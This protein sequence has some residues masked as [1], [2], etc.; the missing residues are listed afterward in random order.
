M[1]TTSSRAAALVALVVL[2]LLVAPG[3]AAAET[4]SGGTIVIEADET[5]L[6]D[7][8]ASGGTVL[9]HGRVTGDLQ[10]FAGNVVIDGEV[11]GNVE[12]F[13]GNVVI[14]GAIDGD[15]VAVAGN[16][17]VRPGASIGGSLEAAGGNVLVLGAV[18]GDARLAGESVRLGPTAAIG[19]SLEYDSA[20]FV[21]DDGATVAGSIE[22]N[23]DMEIGPTFGGLGA[24]PDLSG[25]VAVYGFL[26][27]LVLGAVLLT[28]FP[29]F[30]RAVADRAVGDPVRSGGIGL[31]AL[32]GVPI[33][34]VLVAVTIVGIPLSI[35][36]ALL[37]AMAAW[38]GA[39]YGRLA[40]GD[41]LLSLT[42]YENRWAS[43]LVGLLAVAV[44]V[45][46]PA[47]GWAF[48]IGVLLLGLGALFGALYA[49][50]A[51]GPGV[52]T[53]RPDTSEPTDRGEGPRPA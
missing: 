45:R 13:S 6:G 9:V 23:P 15:V 40:V 28:A 44:L 4:R 17:E 27:N 41:W 14:D 36:G 53:D 10:A 30:S 3:I 29:G 37:F 34:L 20:G 42:D 50:Y 21:R 12:A 32:V 48:S 46:V 2:A 11:G 33:A 49:R 31:L 26:V 38:V 47:V 52:T 24:L 8:E 39:V 35:V 18:S 19:G 16:V 5:V 51:G 22:R 25:A 1:G 43:L 7:L